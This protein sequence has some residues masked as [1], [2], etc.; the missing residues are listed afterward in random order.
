MLQSMVLQSMVLQTVGHNLAKKKQ[1]TEEKN[2][3]KLFELY[4]KHIEEYITICSTESNL[5][6]KEERWGGEINQEFRTDI[7]TLL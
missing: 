2:L 4:M 1:T 3:L 5:K 7:F 6:V